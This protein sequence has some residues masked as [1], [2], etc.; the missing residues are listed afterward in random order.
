[1]D[2]K[3]VVEQ[4]S[5]RWKVKHPDLIA[6]CTSRRAAL[7]RA[8]DHVTYTW[9]PRAKNSARRPAGQ[10]GDGR[11]RRS[12]GR[13]S[14]RPSSRRPPVVI[15]RAGPAPAARRPGSCCCAT[16][17]PSC[18]CSAAI[19]AAATRPLTELG[20]RQAEAAAQLPR[21]AGRHHG[22]HLL[23]AAAG[24]RHRGGR[25]E[26]ARSR[27]RRRRRPDRNGL[28]RLGRADVRR[29]GA[30]AIPNCTALAARHQ[31]HAA[32]RGELRQ[33]CTNG[34]GGRRRGSSPSTAARPCWWCRT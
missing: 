6:A 18:R 31:R 27:R 25:G 4:M 7:A 22:R 24:L 14:R 21:A 2:S 33:P 10:R 29:G 11:R 5:G 28:R 8:F 26:G 9:I 16:G 15:R 23:T 1:M 17:R 34:F 20:R 3:L 32:R 13:R 19:P 12:R 30:S